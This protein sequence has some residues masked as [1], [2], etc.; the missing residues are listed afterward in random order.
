MVRLLT[1]LW[2]VSIC[3]TYTSGLTDPLQGFSSRHIYDFTEMNDAL[4]DHPSHSS[5]RRSF[6]PMETSGS[7]T[8]AKVRQIRG[9]GR[10]QR[11]N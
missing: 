3:V 4:S 10:H 11:K 1:M 7:R 6:N 9:E 8:Q 2:Y 5:S